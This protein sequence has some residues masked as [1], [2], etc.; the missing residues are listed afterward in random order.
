MADE[1]RWGILGTG[2]IA[3]VFAEF[4]QPSNT[5]RLVAVG[6][7]RQAS[8]EE[9]GEK[10]NVPNRHD[11]Y[12]GVLADE[13]VDAIY[14][15]LPNHMHAEWSIRCAEA[16]KHILCEKPAT[17][18]AEELMEVLDAVRRHDVFF[19]EAFMY[20]CH[21]QTA[22][23]AEL[24]GDGEIGEVRVIQSNF[25]Y[26]GAGG[27]GNIRMQ[28]ESS[29][30]AIMDIGCY[31]MSAARIV[32]GAAIGLDGPAEPTDVKGHG[33]IDEQGGVDLYATAS[34]SFPN[35]V[36]VNL[37]CGQYVNVESAIKVWGSKGNIEVTNPWFPGRDGSNPTIRV[38]RGGE[39]EEVEIE[40]PAPL[41]TIEADIVARHIPDRAAP[42]PC[43]T[44]DDSMGNMQALDAW[45]EQI[46]L[47][48]RAEQVAGGLSE[49]IARRPLDPKRIDVGMTFGEIPGVE[50]PVSRLVIGTMG[51]ICGRLPKT[52]AMLDH[53]VEMGGTAI[54]TA[55]VYGTEPKVGQWLK[56]RD[57]REHMVVIGKGAADTN[58][59]P[60]MV[61]EHLA[62]SLE[63]M[64]VDY[65][66]VY[67]MHRDNP[68]VPVAEFV[69]CLNEQKKAGRI[70]A[71]GGSNW[72]IARLREANEYAQS[73]GL[74]PMGANSPNF[75]LA[76]WN[77]PMWFDCIQAVDEASLAFHRETDMPLLAWSSQANGFFTGAFR[78][79]HR[80]DPKIREIVRVWFND[81]N[82]KRLDRV[83]ELAKKKGVTG[84]QIALAYVLAQPL[85]IYA[86]IGPRSI[87][88]MRTSAQAL[89]VA[90]TEDERK[91]LNLETD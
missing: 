59:T 79:E 44:W 81:E 49:P 80:D 84:I 39:T 3:N 86:L 51:H 16:G 12:E 6:S 13:E 32:A 75:T 88:E 70:R 17:S 89:R 20:R 73:K 66:D 18:Y 90:L 63:R 82:F 29:G 52:F 78:P 4:L 58:A 19:M 7:R 56:A 2:T 77:E 55:Y 22:K 69:E 60:E 9:F 35:G 37:C 72:T 33:I 83:L 36:L 42:P 28:N 62:T 5:G 65:F 24:I 87:E 64:G 91:W 10:W 74:T 23:V 61:T 45:R 71:F 8:A 40:S 68:D 31:A 30:G 48:F 50:K 27:H 53:F 54:D 85:N 11:S 47:T 38:T 21:P 34:L 25:C 26:G 1:M 15:S 41:Y 14:I 67:L 57:I 43:M 46:G 76:V